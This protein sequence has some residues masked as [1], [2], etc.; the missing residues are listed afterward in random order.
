MSGRRAPSV[1]PRIDGFEHVGFLGSGGFADVFLYEQQRPR[2]RVAVKVLLQGSLDGAARARF[3]AEADRM[4]QL[5]THPAIVT[6][7]EAGVA[8]DGR[9]Y[10]AMEYCSRPHLGATYRREPLGVAEALRIGIV[11]ECV[12][13]KNILQQPR[14]IDE[15]A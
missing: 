12:E 8:R 10:I 6:V 11:A 9:P 4:A 13:E 15:L 14:P 3:D 2:R 5:S 7:Y 1:P